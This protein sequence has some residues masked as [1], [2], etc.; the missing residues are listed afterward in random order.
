MVKMTIEIRRNSDGAMRGPF[1]ADSY[2][3]VYEWSEGNGACDCVRS[4][5]FYGNECGECGDLAFSIRLCD[6]ATG[7]VIY[8]ELEEEQ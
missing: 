2:L 4:E 8:D 5:V 6:A 1:P 3:T 7:E